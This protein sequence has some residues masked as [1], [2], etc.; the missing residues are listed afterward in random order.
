MFKILALAD[1][2]P[3]LPEI[4]LV[5]TTLVLL[6]LGVMRDKSESFDFICIVAVIAL[7]GAAALVLLSGP[8]LDPGVIS[9]AVHPSRTAPGSLGGR[10][11]VS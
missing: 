4:V 5:V 3:A 10:V 2:Q 1:A 11:R 9:D 7:A 8:G 6:M